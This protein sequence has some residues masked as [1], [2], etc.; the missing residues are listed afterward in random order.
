MRGLR[1]DRLLSD[2]NGGVPPQIYQICAHIGD[3]K[4]L[5]SIEDF[6]KAYCERRTLSLLRRSC[7]KCNTE[8]QLELREFGESNIAFIMT[9]WVNI[10]PG[11]H[12]DDP[13]WKVHTLGSQHLPLTL[14]S[15]YMFSSP[16]SLFEASHTTS[17]EALC[18]QN[19]AYLT[20]R[21]YR[22]AMKQLSQSPPTWGLWREPV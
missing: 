18:T 9:R 17:L 22:S 21:R 13:R 2:T 8:Y 12:P 14:D 3:D 4:L 11:R 5:V 15:E 10:G 7:N 16:L 20:D 6:V 1:A 19:L